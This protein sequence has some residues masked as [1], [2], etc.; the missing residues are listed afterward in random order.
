MGE[1]DI[2]ISLFLIIGRR[3]IESGCLLPFGYGWAYHLWESSSYVAYPIPLNI[4]ARAWRKIRNYFIAPEIWM[5][6][7]G[8]YWPVED[9]V[10]LNMKDYKIAKV[11]RKNRKIYLEEK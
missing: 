1:W 10:I 6:V 3:E 4:I 9:Q 11:D 8:E 5:F 7:R 2:R